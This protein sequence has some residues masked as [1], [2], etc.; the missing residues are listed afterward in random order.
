MKDMFRSTTTSYVANSSTVRWTGIELT[1][2]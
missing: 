1:R 2:E